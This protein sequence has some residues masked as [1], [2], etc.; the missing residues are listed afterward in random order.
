M[1]ISVAA[2][3]V[4]VECRSAPQHSTT[5]VLARRMQERA[6]E[7]TENVGEEGI[8]MG[9]IKTRML[10]LIICTCV[11][12]IAAGRAFAQDRGGFTALVDLGVG[13]QHDA[14][15]DETAVGLAGVNL[16]VGGFLTRDLA[17]MFR[18]SGTNVD[19][20]FGGV[21]YSQTSGV[22]GPAMQF[23]LSDTFNVEAGA[24]VGFWRGDTD[25]ANEGLGLIL[26][27]GV[28]VFNRGKHNLQLGIQYAPAF[29]DP[30][31]VH[32]FGVTFGYQFQ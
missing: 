5:Y 31:T 18:I 2:S 13:V 8:G 15:I 9:R 20:D 29:T 14:G 6:L 21:D 4:H 25:E 1:Q 7:A 27:A 22:V 12:A 17:L 30:G 3:R 26:G 28:S 24:G 16:G 23:W 32:N 11:V 10:R 19:Y